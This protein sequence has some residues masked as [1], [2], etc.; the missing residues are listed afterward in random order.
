MKNT[1]NI[2]ISSNIKNIKWILHNEIFFICCN[3]RGDKIILLKV[4]DSYKLSFEKLT[5]PTHYRY[6]I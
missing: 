2:F 6:Y 1:L 4:H 3:N 5:L